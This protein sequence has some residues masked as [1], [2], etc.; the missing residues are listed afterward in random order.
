MKAF[1]AV[2]D[3][4]EDAIFSTKTHA[5]LEGGR[6]VKCP[7]GKEEAKFRCP[8][9]GATNMVCAACLVKMHPDQ[10]FHHVEEWD[11]SGFVR[12]HCG[13]S[14]TSCILHTE[15]LVCPNGPKN[16]KGG[17]KEGTGQDGCGCDKWNTCNRVFFVVAAMQ[18]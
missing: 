16:E 12:R 2:E 15:G 4:L 13:R 10:N 8:E 17:V 18:E 3:Q 14:G 1:L 7:C 6:A 11:G 9:C 5:S